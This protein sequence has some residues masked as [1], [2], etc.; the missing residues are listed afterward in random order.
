MERVR[1]NKPA[2]KPIAVRRKGA[3]QMLNCGTWKVDQLIADGLIDGRKAGK[4]LLVTVASIEAYLANL[5]RAELK[6]ARSK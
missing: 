2:I 4:I 3:A 6:Y 5:P 1:K